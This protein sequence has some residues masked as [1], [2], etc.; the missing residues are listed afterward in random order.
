M[1]IVCYG[2]PVGWVRL[3]IVPSP[4]CY[5]GLPNAIPGCRISSCGDERRGYVQVMNAMRMLV[6]K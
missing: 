6:S 5:I 2:V 1:N 3:A 4:S